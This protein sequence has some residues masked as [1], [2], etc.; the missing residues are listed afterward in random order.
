MMEYTSPCEFRQISG[1][2]P[3]LDKEA[4]RLIER[5]TER[6]VHWMEELAA[7]YPHVMAGGRPIRSEGDNRFTPSFETYT[8]GELA[9]Y[10][11][12]TLE[13]LE[14]YYLDMAADGKNPAEL[15]L[16]HTAESSG[17]ASLERAEDAQKAR[18]EKGSSAASSR[19]GTECDSLSREGTSATIT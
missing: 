3:D 1:S 6:S 18:M 4:P 15:I 2:V 19:L 16:R 11:V 7:R 10:S 8:R 9:T 17:F 5:L 14:A 13:L 12:K